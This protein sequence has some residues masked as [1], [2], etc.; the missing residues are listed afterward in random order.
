LAKIGPVDFE[1]T[2]LTE[3][4]KIKDETAVEHAARPAAAKQA[5]HGDTVSRRI[6]FTSHT[7][8]RTL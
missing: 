2:G 1:I 8:T 4:V 6:D 3:V 5:V 7:G